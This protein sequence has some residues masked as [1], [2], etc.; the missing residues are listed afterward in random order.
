L[1]SSTATS[2][3]A[4]QVADLTAA[5]MGVAVTDRDQ[6]QGSGPPSALRLQRGDV[7][8]EESLLDL[9]VA[10]TEGDGYIGFKE[11]VVWWTS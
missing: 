10:D 3:V 1:L 8:R 11:F 7:S 5:A 4:T 9:E 2:V 6:S